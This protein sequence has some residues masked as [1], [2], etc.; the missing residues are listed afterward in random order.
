MTWKRRQK[1]WKKLAEKKRCEMWSPGHG[2]ATALMSSQQLLTAQ[3]KPDFS[4][5]RGGAHKASILMEKPVAFV[6]AGEGRLVLGGVTSGRLTTP[7]D[8]LHPC[9]YA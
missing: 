5:S 7:V 3:N 8:V 2:T 4:M 1:A 6:Q 9:T